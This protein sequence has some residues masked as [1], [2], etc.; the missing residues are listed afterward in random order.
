M[1]ARNKRKYT[2]LIGQK[3]SYVMI[4]SVLWT[5]M[6]KFWLLTSTLRFFEC[7]LV[8]STHPFLLMS[9]T[10]WRW[11]LLKILPC[12]NVVLVEDWRKLL[13]CYRKICHS[14]EELIEGST[15]WIELSHSSSAG[16]LILC[17][18]GHKS[19]YTLCIRVRGDWS[20]SVVGI[21]LRI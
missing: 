7:C 19:P 18:R 8:I 4:V 20:R 6:A 3:H 2:L 11:W 13:N 12:L 21:M 10:R 16:L 14:L 9:K 17:L 5:R 15:S 1:Q